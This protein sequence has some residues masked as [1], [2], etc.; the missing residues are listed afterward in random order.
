MEVKKLIKKRYVFIMLMIILIYELFRVRKYYSFE[1]NVYDQKNRF[2]IEQLMEMNENDAIIGLGF[3]DII[4]LKK[5]RINICVF[6]QKNY[7]SLLIKD[8]DVIYDENKKTFNYNVL[9]NMNIDNPNYSEIVTYELDG[10]I[11]QGYKKYAV[12]YLYG[13]NTCWINFYDIFKWKHRKIGDEFNIKLIIHY[14]VDGFPYT[15]ELNYKVKCCESYPKRLSDI[16]Y[17]LLR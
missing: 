5:Y 16:F 11:I 17:L 9:Y 10:K 4:Y 14:E 6:S 7:H 8:I 12:T 13:E 15:Q 3:Q 1:N 2:T